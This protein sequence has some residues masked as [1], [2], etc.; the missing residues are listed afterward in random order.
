MVAGSVRMNLKYVEISMGQRTPLGMYTK[1]PSEKTAAFRAAK[2][3]SD[4]GIW[5]QHRLTSDTPMID[6]K[7]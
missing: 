2:K 6:C 7:I 4:A 3:L 5:R 1:E